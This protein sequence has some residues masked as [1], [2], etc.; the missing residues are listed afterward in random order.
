MILG[1]G[2]W[3]ARVSNYL[4][5][6]DPLRFP[7]RFGIIY[8]GSALR[9]PKHELSTPP[10]THHSLVPLDGFHTHTPDPDSRF[11]TALMPLLWPP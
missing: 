2:E 10:T 4:V 6:D 1:F 11:E 8:G 5:V 9:S 3:W 7:L